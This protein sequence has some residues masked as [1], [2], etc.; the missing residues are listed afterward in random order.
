MRW[1]VWKPKNCT[2]VINIDFRRRTLGLVL[3][4]FIA[5]GDFHPTELPTCKTSVE[6]WSTKTPPSWILVHDGDAWE[7]THDAAG[8]RDAERHTFNHGGAKLTDFLMLNGRRRR[9]GSPLKVG[10]GGFK[11]FN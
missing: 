9:S 8:F 5:N 4:E 7:K 2:V 11:A 10:G 1:R 3:Y 6:D